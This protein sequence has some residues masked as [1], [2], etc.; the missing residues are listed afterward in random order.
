M[1]HLNLNNQNNNSHKKLIS[2]APL[3]GNLSNNY[4]TIHS[5]KKE[6]GGGSFNYN[7][8]IGNFNA[9]IT[10]HNVKGY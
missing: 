10:N 4:K 7:V 5:P 8:M 9:T 1:T 3:P 6:N 2:P